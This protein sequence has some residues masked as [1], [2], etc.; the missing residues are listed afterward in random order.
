MHHQKRLTGL[1]ASALLATL[2][3]GARQAEAVILTPALDVYIEDFSS[4]GVLDGV[5]DAIFNTNGLL[6]GA[7]LLSSGA[8]IESRPL[9]IF[10]VSPFAGM[11]LTS[12]VLTGAGAGVDHNLAPETI[13]GTFFLSSGDG[14]ATLSDFSQAAT[15]V[16]VHTFP[17]ADFPF[18]STLFPFALPV[19][20]PLQTLLDGGTSFA[21]FRVHSDE[22][23]VFINAAEVDPSFSVDTRFPG[24]ALTLEFAQGPV[25][26]EP[27]SLIL[28]GSG[29]LGLAGW[30]RK[31]RAS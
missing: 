30:R 19:T 5:A 6:A 14:T 10:D 13:D 15:L 22:L 2:L 29:L 4:T 21:E 3:G 18:F 11:S 25:I 9:I 28:L 7:G 24:P 20:S 1:V 17:G 31:F 12:V 16:G 8:A 27:S 23:T 26:P